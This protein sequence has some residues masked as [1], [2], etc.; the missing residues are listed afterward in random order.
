[1]YHYLFYLTSTALVLISYL[2]CV[3][4][5]VCV[6]TVYLNFVEI[7]FISQTSTKIFLIVT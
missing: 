6:Y 3:Y 2:F 7:V 4:L 1:M 5:I